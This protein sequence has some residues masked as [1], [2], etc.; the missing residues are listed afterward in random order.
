MICVGGYQFSSVK[1]SRQTDA[2]CSWLQMSKGLASMASHGP[3]SSLFATRG[4]GGLYRE[5]RIEGMGWQE[6]GI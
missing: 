5:A 3:T 6:A 2:G 1:G 4:R